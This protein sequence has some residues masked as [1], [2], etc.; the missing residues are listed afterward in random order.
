MFDTDKFRDRNSK[1]NSVYISYQLPDPKSDYS[2]PW[3]RVFDIGKFGLQI[4]NFL[5]GFFLLL[6]QKEVEST[7]RG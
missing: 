1:K 7:A 4:H 2:I 5:S 3:T 6:G